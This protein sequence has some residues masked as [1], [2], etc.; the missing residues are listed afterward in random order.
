VEI[1]NNTYSFNVWCD[2]VRVCWYYRFDIRLNN[3]ICSWFNE[4]MDVNPI[5]WGYSIRLI[6][7]CNFK[8]AEIM[9]KGLMLIWIVG[10]IVVIGG[11]SQLIKKYG[12]L[13]IFVVIFIVVSIFGLLTFMRYIK[14]N[15]DGGQSTD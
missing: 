12:L 3:S 10:L 6:Y 9:R 11:G 4:G 7:R 13:D 14:R 1:R 2:S 5:V 8:K 15:D